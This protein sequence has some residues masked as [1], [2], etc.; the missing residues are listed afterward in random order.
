[1]A[2]ASIII[3]L[4]LI[5]LGLLLFNPTTRWAVQKWFLAFGLIFMVGGFLLK[6]HGHGFCREAACGQEVQSHCKRG[7]EMAH[8]KKSCDMNSK[9]TCP[10]MEKDSATEQIEVNKRVVVN[11]GKEISIEIGKITFEAN[12]NTEYL[13][14]ISPEDA[15]VTGKGISRQTEGFTFNP[16][17]AGAGKHKIAANGTDVIELIVN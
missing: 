17:V 13:L 10:M 9:K 15:V 16:S 8:C 7:G 6:H 11:D 3:G 14:T 12:D 5:V 2:F 1:M 4:V